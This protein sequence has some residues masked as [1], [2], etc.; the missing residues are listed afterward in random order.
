MNAIHYDPWIESVENEFDRAAE[1]ERK[2]K[3][4]EEF[5]RGYLE[6]LDECDRKRDIALRLCKT[7]Y[8]GDNACVDAG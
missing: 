5:E 2:R 4:R 1:R 8:T 3:A 6:Y 7:Y